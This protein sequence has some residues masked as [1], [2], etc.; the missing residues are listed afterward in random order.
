[1]NILFDFVTLQDNCVNGGMLYTDKVL[2]ELLADGAIIFALYDKKKPIPEAYQKIVDD[3]KI[4]T[5]DINENIEEFIKENDVSKL[6]IGIAQRYYKH[7]LSNLSCKIYIVCHDV[8]DLCLNYSN[9]NSLSNHRLFNQR[10]KIKPK[11]NIVYRLLRR[12][13]WIYK[14]VFKKKIAII[15]QYSNLVKLIKKDN[16]QLIAVSEYSKSAII[17]F[18]GAP[19]NEIVV[20]YSPLKVRSQAV[21]KQNKFDFLKGKKYFLFVSGD[22]MP[23]NLDLFMSQWQKFCQST[24]YQYY[25]LICGRVKINEKNVFVA[26]KVSNEELEYL[27]KNAFALVYPSFGEGFGYPPL[28]AGQYGTPSICSN[29]TS[30]PEIYGDM[31]VYCS[32]FYPEDLFGAMLKMIKA[33][34]EYSSKTLLKVV[35]ISERQKADFEKLK[36]LLFKKA[37]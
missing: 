4:K 36:A 21:D 23:K 17:Y 9:I 32:P 10:Y 18:L 6:F 19:K 30:I 1:M 16:V 8:C 12:I 37:V 13:Y 26:D 28:E 24:A 35:E 5:V 11:R 3:N 14:R 25:A 22:R 33:H 7:D 29:V 34:D 20:L 15:K 27:Y 2:R 31:V